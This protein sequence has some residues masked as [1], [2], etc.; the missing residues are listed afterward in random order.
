MSEQ[1]EVVGQGGEDWG[2]EEVGSDEGNE[3]NEGDGAG[4]GLAYHDG[5]PARADGSSSG[6]SPSR[7]NN[8][9]KSGSKE[10][11]TKGMSSSLSFSELERAIGE[12][13]AM[14]LTSS[15]S[16]QSMGGESSEGSPGNKISKSNS[17]GSM[18]GGNGNGGSRKGGRGNG[19]RDGQR[20]GN[21]YNSGR[22]QPP[23]LQ[24][25]TLYTDPS[26]QP[27]MMMMPPVPTST[28]SRLMQGPH[29]QGQGF[30]PP[31][32]ALQRQSLHPS[33]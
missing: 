15:N 24:Q 17:R 27:M 21:H 20:N 28:G 18:N 8:P 19:N 1:Q 14:G 23:Q 5:S 31:D 10:R 2:W 25:Q 3:G 16:N 30:P 13:L 7:A 33:P 29:L 26:G 32:Q 12:S 22:A 11:L 9:I 6:E 4:Q